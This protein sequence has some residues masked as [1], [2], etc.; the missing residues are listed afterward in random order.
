MN[1]KRLVLRKIEEIGVKEASKLFGVSLGTISN[2][3]TG[4]SDPSLA[5]AQ[6]LASEQPEPTGPDELTMWQGKEVII[7]LPV[8]RSFN[9]DTHYTLFA[10]YARY[11][12]EKVGMIQEKGTL[13]YEARNTLA[14]KAL[15]I[16]P[17][18][19]Y[20]V[21]CDDDMILPCGNVE[22]FNGRYQANVSTQS[23]GFNALSRIMSH[24]EDKKIVGT[25][26]FGRHAKGKAQCSRGFASDIENEKL[27]T[28]A[29]SGLLEDEWVGTG[30]MRIHTDVFLA[31]DEEI[32]KDRWPECRHRAAGIDFGYFNPMGVRIG[33]DVSFCRRAREIGIKSY[34]DTSLICLHEGNMMYGPKN[35]S[36]K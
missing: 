10:N 2:W 20:V 3:S 6:L 34:I 17:R 32:K 13:I 9:A 8:Y 14:H 19:K 33:E 18:P 12:P 1:L 28:G 27:H 22:L 36:F 7:L 26:Y 35:T 4:K 24:P 31:M 30:F 16:T 23:A 21:F 15:K 11:G 5:A 29:Y 25:L